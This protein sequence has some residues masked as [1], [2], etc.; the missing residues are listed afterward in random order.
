M[1]ANVEELEDKGVA[2]LTATSNNAGTTAATTGH[3]NLLVD[4]GETG[5]KRERASAVPVDILPVGEKDVAN[6]KVASYT[7][8]SSDLELIKD[9]LRNNVVCSA[10]KEKE[11]TIL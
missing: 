9:A 7:K 10:L 11:H 5:R 1:G 6:H 8:T 4:G 2:A 3:N